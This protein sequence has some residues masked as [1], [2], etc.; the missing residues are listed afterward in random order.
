MFHS[1]VACFA[2]VIVLSM[3]CVG[4]LASLLD[5]P[6]SQQVCLCLSACFFAA[7]AQD[8]VSKLESAAQECGIRLKRLDKKSEKAACTVQ[9]AR[10]LQL[11]HA[12]ETPAAVLAL[13]LPLLV[14]KSC[15]RLMSIP[16]RA[17]GGVLVMLE[18][19][20][21]PEQH[22]LI[23]QFHQ[24]VVDSLKAAAAG[25]GASANGGVGE[26]LAGL[27]PQVK[28]LAGVESSTPANA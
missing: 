9:K 25:D 17:I 16:G 13:V 3:F 6:H 1:M 28:V 10:L 20:M 22:A 4:Q 23:Q 11:L 2:L 7:R 26:Q 27:V 8:F 24:L 15:N 12:E 19:N 18:G 5:I 21:Q 14:L